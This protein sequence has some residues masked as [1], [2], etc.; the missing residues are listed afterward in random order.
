M[1]TQMIRQRVFNEI[2][3]RFAFCHYCQTDQ[4]RVARIFSPKFSLGVFTK[5]VFV[6]GWGVSLNLGAPYSQL[7]N[8]G[9][10]KS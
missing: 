5:P 2:L 3:L 8:E 1:R 4:G 10:A 7:Q 6:F 9:L